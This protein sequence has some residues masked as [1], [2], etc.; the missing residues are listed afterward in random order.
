MM[1]LLVQSVGKKKAAQPWDDG[2]TAD[3]STAQPPQCLQQWPFGWECGQTQFWGSTHA[4]LWQSPSCQTHVCCHEGAACQGQGNSR[5]S[6]LCGRCRSP[7]IT[8]QGVRTWAMATMESMLGCE[9]G[10]H[11]LKT[12]L[13]SVG[14]LVTNSLFQM[15]SCSLLHSKGFIIAMDLSD[16]AFQQMPTMTTPTPPDAKKVE[17]DPGDLQQQKLE[18]KPPTQTKDSQFQFSQFVKCN[19]LVT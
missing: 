3:S 4:C 7:S 18:S 15:A 19:F 11:D 1:R 12:D 17:D 9:F 14:M 6:H 5:E 13:I 10:L 8:E 16:P 2:L